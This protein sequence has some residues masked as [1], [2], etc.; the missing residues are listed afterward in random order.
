MR[1]AALTT[2]FVSPS[3]NIG[4][5]AASPARLA[6]LNTHIIQVVSRCGQSKAHAAA[7]LQACRIGSGRRHTR[8][9]G[10]Y[11][12]KNSNGEL[13]RELSNSGS[14]TEPDQW[15]VMPHVVRRPVACHDRGRG[16][17]PDGTTDP[18]RSML[19]SYHGSCCTSDASATMFQVAMGSLLLVKPAGSSEVEAVPL[20]TPA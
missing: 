5:T 14:S 10:S 20:Q 9:G 17:A 16:A 19:A 15:C 11:Y 3:C 7:A 12:Y 1:C 18:S 6:S 13:L 8:H 4:H 2:P